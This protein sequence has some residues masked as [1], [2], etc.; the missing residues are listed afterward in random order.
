MTLDSTSES[1]HTA[2]SSDSGDSSDGD[3][4]SPVVPSSEIPV[5]LGGRLY[6]NRPLAR[7]YTPD[8]EWTERSSSPASYVTSSTSLLPVHSP[9]SPQS[10]DFS[11]NPPFI[12]P[13]SFRQPT[14]DIERESR[15]RIDPSSSPPLRR[16]VNI[17]PI[18]VSRIQVMPAMRFP[19]PDSPPVP[20]TPPSQMTPLTFHS[21][22]QAMF[23]PS[24]P[25]TVTPRFYSWQNHP[26]PTLPTSPTIRGNLHSTF[27]RRGATPAH[28]HI[29]SAV[30]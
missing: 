3:Q 8:M 1:E 21:Q 27:T 26:I 25:P 13:P 7:T 5:V 22:S 23:T 14:P 30:V 18:N 11:D 10:P 4:G 28:V 12:P 16:T 6:N 29:P 9:D 20:S 17:V 19:S 2:E 15:V 24:P